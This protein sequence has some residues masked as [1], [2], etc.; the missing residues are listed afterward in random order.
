MV[1]ARRDCRCRGVF[2]VKRRARQILVATG[3]IV[4]VW[5]PTGTLFLLALLTAYL[6]AGVPF[7]FDMPVLRGFNFAVAL[8]L[9]PNL[10]R[11]CWR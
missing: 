7:Q 3:N 9:F 2:L 8:V 5:R 11:C 6:V 4:S 1:F 10:L